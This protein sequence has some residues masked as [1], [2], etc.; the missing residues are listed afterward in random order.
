MLKLDTS[1]DKGCWDKELD[2]A[3]KW[4]DFDNRHS[5][6]SQNLLLLLLHKNGVKIFMVLAREIV[7]IMS[8]HDCYIQL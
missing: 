5:S 2:Y 8:A 3:C 1:Q 6:G 4:F 7:Y